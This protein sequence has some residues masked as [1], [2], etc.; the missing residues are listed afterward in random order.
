MKLSQL[1][2]PLNLACSGGDPE[3]TGLTCDSRQV[4]PGMLFAALPGART[5]GARFLAQAKAQ[6]ENRV[7]LTKTKRG[8]QIT[9]HISDGEMDL[10]AI[11]LYVPDKA[12][13][14][15]VR[16]RFYRDPEGVYKLVL[17]SLTGDTGLAREYLR[18]HE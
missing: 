5:D 6:R 12:Q 1:L 2:I 17:A 7:D 8:Y 18:E 4:G 13:A 15:M 16:E 3:L 10:M 14:K 11:S 9:C